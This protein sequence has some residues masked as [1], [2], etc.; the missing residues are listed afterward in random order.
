MSLSAEPPDANDEAASEQ[1][2]FIAFLDILGFSELV[3]RNDHTSLRKKYDLFLGVVQLDLAGGKFKTEQRDG[4]TV[5]VGDLTHAKVHAL[6]V[7][8]TL[9]LWTD[10]LSMTAFL[11]IV[12][13]AR[14]L[15]VSGL[16][17]GFPLRGAI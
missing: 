4:E 2:A 5:V 9:L 6:L 11:H 10:K 17:T 7:S 13:V 1:N 8:D 16:F 12:I 15:L 3:E 14:S